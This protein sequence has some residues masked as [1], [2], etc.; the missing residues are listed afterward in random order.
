MRK[1]T[2][3]TFILLEIS[4][5][6]G[7]TIITVATFS[8]KDEIK[9][10]KTET[11]M[12]ASPTVF[13]FETSLFATK[14][15]TFEIIKISATMAV[16]QKIPITFQLMTVAALFNEIILKMKRRRTPTQRINVFLL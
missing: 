12:I 2:G 10:E 6:I 3:E 13:V 11:A 16:P 1:G 8:Q 4:K 5:A 14:A 9:P 15:G 7:A